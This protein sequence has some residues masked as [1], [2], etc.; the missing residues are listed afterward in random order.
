MPAKAGEEIPKR[1]DGF[2]EYRHPDDASFDKFVHALDRAYHRPWLLFWRSVLWGLGTALGATIGAGIV[3][4]GL[5]YALSTINFTPYAEKI[6][7]LII[8][9]TIRSQLDSSDSQQE[10]IDQL[11][12][13]LE[14]T[15]SQ[16][17]TP[18]PSAT[19]QP[20]PTP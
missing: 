15:Q 17:A 1:D 8:P 3:F 10:R 7:E 14:E 9:E 5:F 6:Q 13:E 20:T 2:A 18:T 19:P 12:E 4:V 11:L 16:L